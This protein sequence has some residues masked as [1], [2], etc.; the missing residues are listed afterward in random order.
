MLKAVIF[1]MHANVEALQAMLERI[2]VHEVEAIMRF[3]DIVGY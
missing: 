3:G 2:K 1:D